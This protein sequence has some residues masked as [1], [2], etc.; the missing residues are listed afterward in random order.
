VFIVTASV[1]PFAGGLITASGYSTPFMIGSG[2]V[3]VIL[4]LLLAGVPELSDRVPLKALFALLGLAFAAYGAA[5]WPL[6]PRVAA[7]G[8]GGCASI[9][10]MSLVDDD[11]ESE[12][13]PAASGGRRSADASRLAQI[14]DPESVPGSSIQARK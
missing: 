6:V 8:R 3:V 11:S 4:H 7:S 1:A 5:F 10:G 2:V 12:R 9:F 13:E 14:E